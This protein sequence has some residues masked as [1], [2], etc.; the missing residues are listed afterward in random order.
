MAYGVTQVSKK[1]YAIWV[2]VDRFYKSTHFLPIKSTFESGRRVARM[3]G[4]LSIN[5]DSTDSKKE[6]RV[7]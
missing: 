1:F 2:I 3:R 5:K 7:K 4:N 6:K